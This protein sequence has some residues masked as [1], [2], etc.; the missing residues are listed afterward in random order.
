LTAGDQK[1][2]RQWHQASHTLSDDDELPTVQAVCQHASHQGKH[3]DRQAPGQAGEAEVE[4]RVGQ[5]EDQ[6]D[7]CRVLDLRPNPGRQ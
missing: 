6:P 2:Q 4:W 7:I 1:A 5:V 3:D